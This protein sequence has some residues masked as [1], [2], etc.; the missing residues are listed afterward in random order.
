M[1]MGSVGRILRGLVV[2]LIVAASIQSYGNRFFYY[3][4]I[5]SNLLAIVLLGGQAL[6]PDWMRTNAFFR[7]AVTLYMTMTGFVYAVVLAPLGVDVGDY[8]PWANFVHHNLAPT[9]V[10]VDWLLFPPSQKLHRNAPWLWLAFPVVYFV[11]SLING[12]STG[13]YPYP[14]LNPDSVGGPGGVALYAAVILAIF[15]LVS[16]FIS[17]WADKRGVLPSSDQ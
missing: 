3:F 6:W 7:G 17:W 4:T 12:S 8:A 10:L 5:L 2:V 15:A 9:A 13:F 1:G 16:W 14:F 11:F